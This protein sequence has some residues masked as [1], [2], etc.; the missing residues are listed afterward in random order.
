MDT[1]L[2]KLSQQFFDEGR[3]PEI[4]G[5][6]IGAAILMVLHVGLKIPC[7]L[8]IDETLLYFELFV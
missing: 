2:V 8:L 1:I 7:F 5:D 3:G 6:L 4:F